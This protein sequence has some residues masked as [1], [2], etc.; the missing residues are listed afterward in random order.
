MSKAF[1]LLLRSLFANHV[2]DSVERDLLSLQRIDVGSAEDV[3]G[4]HTAS[5]FG[6]ELSRL[7]DMEATCTLKR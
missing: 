5:I 2:T 3:S 4:V 7:L 6:I 1:L